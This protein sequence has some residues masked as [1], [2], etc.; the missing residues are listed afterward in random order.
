MEKSMTDPSSIV[1]PKT[2]QQWDLD[3][4]LKKVMEL[5]DSLLKIQEQNILLSAQAHD[6]QD[7]KSE[8]NDQVQLLMDKSRENKHLHQELSRLAGLMDTQLKELESLKAIA[9]D[10][11]HQLK[12][13]QQER[14]LLAEMLTKAEH[15]ARKAAHTVKNDSV[16]V[17]TNPV[18]QFASNPGG[19]LRYLKGK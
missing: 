5:Q 12:T 10:L 6:A 19:W 2:G 11:D 17:D 8:L 13:T 15:N 18:G 16:P 4:L 3:S 1:D 7:L 9:L 14:D